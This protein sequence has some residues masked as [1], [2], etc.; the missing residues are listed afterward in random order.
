LLFGMGA[1]QT[2]LKDLRT[3]GVES[4][5]VEPASP[6]SEVGLEFEAEGRTEAVS[7]PPLP[8]G[9]VDGVQEAM[10]EPEVL[11]EF[12]VAPK[13]AFGEHQLVVDPAP[14][15]TRVVEAP[16]ASQSKSST[17]TPSV[18]PVGDRLTIKDIG[19]DARLVRKSVDKSGQM[20]EPDSNDDI[21]LYDFSGF[22]GYGGVPGKS[23][24][25]VFGGHLDSGST[26][27]R[28]GTLPPPCPAVLSNL[29]SV[30]RGS[31]IVVHLKGSIYR[32]VVTSNQSVPVGANWSQIVSSTSQE[33]I[34]I[35]TCDGDFNYRTQTYNRRLVVRATRAK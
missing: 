8:H 25:A 17:K 20:P 33:S 7:V 19:V 3:Q 18:K 5:A 15:T 31:E 6:R 21:V 23:G 11:S 4:Q 9:S 10:D 14:I 27:C 32:Y 26:P 28:G 22:K 13:D 29:G 30:Q 2:S 24:N 34:T 1:A 16:A 12:D 35:I